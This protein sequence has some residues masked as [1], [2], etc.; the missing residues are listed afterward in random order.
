MKNKKHQ[1]P[2]LVC[3]LTLSF[4]TIPLT[5]CAQ[6]KEG[7]EKTVEWTVPKILT[8][9]LTPTHKDQKTDTAT[10][11]LTVKA[12]AEAEKQLEELEAKERANEALQEVR[13]KE[14]EE[15]EE[16]SHDAVT[17]DQILQQIRR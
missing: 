17:E 6:V 5:S 11:A 7:A 8:A 4:L 3:V 1:I 13:R 12:K 9:P 10:G 2:Q 15:Q 14:K 16:R